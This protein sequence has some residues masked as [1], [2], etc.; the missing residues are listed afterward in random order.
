MNRTDLAY[1]R[2]AAEGA[3]GF[4]L[5]VAFYDTL[6]GDLRR[7]A[8]AERTNDIEMRCR[9]VNHAL[10]VIGHLEDWVQQ[11]S[12]GELARKLVA[13]YA[14]LRLK[15]IEAQALRSPKVLEEQMARVLEVREY[16]QQIDQSTLP[17]RPEIMPPTR[18][19]SYPGAFT[20]QAE[21]RHGNWS[22]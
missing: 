18:M 5:L 12:D 4:G 15:L 1:R 13:F 10:L 19:P 9:E 2:T 6:A 16:W 3:S 14:S 7:A 21:H 11:G 8:T 20:P 22:A 17:S